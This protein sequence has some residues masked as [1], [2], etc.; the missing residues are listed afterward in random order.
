MRRFANLGRKILKTHICGGLMTSGDTVLRYVFYGCNKS[1]FNVI[2][3]AAR[4]IMN[5]TSPSRAV[6]RRNCCLDTFE[7]QFAHSWS[8]EWRYKR[9]PFKRSGMCT[10]SRHRRTLFFIVL[11]TTRDVGTL[12]FHARLLSF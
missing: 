1:M 3:F 2:H 7:I 12:R 5:P 11:P 6:R 9:G 10:P 8:G 4:G